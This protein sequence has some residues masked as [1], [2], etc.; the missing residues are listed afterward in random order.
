[1]RFAF[2]EKK[3]NEE[4]KEPP[5]IFEIQL[6]DRSLQSSFRRKKE[7]ETEGIE[8]DIG[9][10]LLLHPLPL[11][12]LTFSKFAVSEKGR[13]ETGKEREKIKSKMSVWGFFQCLD[14]DFFL[15]CS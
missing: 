6:Y 10:R 3:E 7:A 12:T 1:M 13:T 9:K 4:T 11:R 15:K 14:R 8:E 5:L 2:L